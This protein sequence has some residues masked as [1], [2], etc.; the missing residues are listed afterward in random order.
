MKLERA[1][2]NNSGLYAAVFNARRQL[3]LRSPSIDYCQEKAP[4]LYS[5]LVTRVR[6]WSPDDI[7]HSI[8]AAALRD[9]WPEW[10]IKDS[11]G[12]LQLE[13]FG[14]QP[15]FDARWLFLDGEIQSSRAMRSNF[16]RIESIDALLAWRNAWDGNALLGAQIFTRALLGTPG[17]HIFAG[18]QDGATVCGFVANR[19][20]DVLGLSNYFGLPQ[21]WPDVIAH[22]R[23]VFGNIDLVGYERDSQTLGILHE[24]GFETVGDLTVWLKQPGLTEHLGRD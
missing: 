22:C 19:T 16:G 3:W 12:E 7:F 10:S 21:Y 1:I 18:R 4:P 11:F 20:D 14:F 23:S 13:R 5:N 8:D 15:L 2:A 6:N 17:F 24:I 9:G